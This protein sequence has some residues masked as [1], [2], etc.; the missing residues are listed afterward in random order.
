MGLSACSDA[1]QNCSVR[2]F[3]GLPNGLFFL[4]SRSFRPAGHDGTTYYT[5]LDPFSASSIY[6]ICLRPTPSCH[7]C[8]EYSLLPSVRSVR[9]P[10]AGVARA[11]SILRL[12]YYIV[13]LTLLWLH[14]WGNVTQPS[15]TWITPWARDIL[16][17][18]NR[19][20]PTEEISHV[21]WTRRFITLQRS[22]P[23]SRSR[24]GWIQ[25]SPSILILLSQ[26]RLSS[27]P[28]SFLQLF[29]PKFCVHFSSFSCLPYTP[30]ILSSMISP[31]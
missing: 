6:V 14:N 26:L 5:S 15:E 4:L 10:L 23:W 7:S 29:Q 20:S 30:T 8:A 31:L 3:L 9:A 21:L 22:R 11:T 19:P 25:S 18:L 1:T 2:L 27:M 13:F 17:K 12:L 24:A 16:E 28:V